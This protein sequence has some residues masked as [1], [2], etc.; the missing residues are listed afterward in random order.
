MPRKLKRRV[1]GNEVSRETLL[2]TPHRAFT[3]MY[4]IGRAPNVRTAMAQRGF[5]DAEAERG[6]ALLAIVTRGLPTRTTDIEV[7]MATKELDDSDEELIGMIGAAFTRF[8]DAHESV[9]TG[10][11]PIVGPKAVQNVAT[12]LERLNELDKTEDGREA[13]ARLAQVGVDGKRRRE[14]AALVN[15]A[16]AKD[17]MKVDE[18]ALKAEEKYEEALLD[19]RDWYVEWAS[20]ARIVVKRRDYLILLGLAERRS[21]GSGGGGGDDNL[22]IIDP[23]PFMDPS[24]PSDP[25][26]PNSGGT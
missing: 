25:N 2:D 19:L 20:I 22:D 21:P 3:L 23:T 4:G 17:K 11:A 16:R 24:K 1:A 8:P 13:L 7:A 15:T 6:Q 10:I 12:L 14:L 26:D 9:L 18:A 5:T